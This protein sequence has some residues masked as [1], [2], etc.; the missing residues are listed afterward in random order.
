LRSTP[1]A[2]WLGIGSAAL[3]PTAHHDDAL[4]RPLAFQCDGAVLGKNRCNTFIEFR[5][6]DGF[7]VSTCGTLSFL[8]TVFRELRAV[9]FP[10]LCLVRIGLVG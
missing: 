2:H 6:L 5:L 4:H 10:I 1:L 3:P 7:L 8:S 9:R